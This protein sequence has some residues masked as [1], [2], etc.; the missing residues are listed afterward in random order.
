MLPAFTKVLTIFISSMM[1]AM[2]RGVWWNLFSLLTSQ[3]STNGNK[4][5]LVSYDRNT[6]HEEHLKLT[7][8]VSN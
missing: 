8:I 4:T 1:T 5:F 2:M 3:W 7:R 6:N